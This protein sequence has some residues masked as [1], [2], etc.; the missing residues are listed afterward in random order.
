MVGM[1]WIVVADD[2]CCRVFEMRGAT[3][4]WREVDVLYHPDSRLHARDL[5][6][7]APG[8]NV[9]GT[10]GH[11]SFAQRHDP[12]QN[13]A[14]RFAGEIAAYL[15]DAIANRGVQNLVLIAAPASLGALRR[16]LSQ[17]VSA[18]VGMELAKDLT[19]HTVAEIRASVLPALQYRS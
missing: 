16:Q 5:V 15:E 17:R 10:G 7:A 18:M 13:A 1:T 9:S 19:R 12:K 6:S 14:R 11:H 8:R 4:P 3:E 2:S